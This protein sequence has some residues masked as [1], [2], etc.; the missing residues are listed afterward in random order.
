MRDGRRHDNGMRRREGSVSEFRQ[1][2][3]LR[4]H[5]GI[6]QRPA[7][8]E[9]E[10]ADKGYHEREDE[11]VVRSDDW[12]QR[13]HGGQGGHLEHARAARRSDVIEQGAISVSGPSVSTRWR[14]SAGHD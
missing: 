14:R 1:A 5:H 11:W 12:M 10:E 7:D 4:A 2:I 9:S 13:L 3:G 8:G 6:E